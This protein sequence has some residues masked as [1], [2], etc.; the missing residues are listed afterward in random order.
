MQ[1]KRNNGP[2]CEVSGKAGG[3]VGRWHPEPR[4]VAT[5][6]QREAG[7]SLKKDWNGEDGRFAEMI[8]DRQG[9]SIWWLLFSL[10]SG[11][12]SHLLKGR[13][14]SGCPGEVILE[15]IIWRERA[16]GQGDRRKS[17]RQPGSTWCSQSTG[18]VGGRG[19]TRCSGA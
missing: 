8:A 12:L 6:A 19:E 16:S 9:I 18:R 2:E 11:M 13:R 17:M 4:R 7:F 14:R 10:C 1:R 15:W 3:M 5:W